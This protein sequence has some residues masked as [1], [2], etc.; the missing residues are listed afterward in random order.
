MKTIPHRPR[1]NVLA[2]AIALCIGLAGGMPAVHADAPRARDITGTAGAAKQSDA[3]PARYT[4]L[5][6]EP[7]LA[8]YQGGIGH[9]AEPPRIAGGRHAGRL[10][11]HS[12]AATAW[13]AHL[14]GQQ[15]A[16][17][18]DA[19]QQVSRTLVPVFTFQHALNGV[20]VEL[21]PAEADAIARRA[22]VLL[23]ERER[24][25]ELQTDRGPAF[26]GADTIWDGSSTGGIATQGEGVVAGIIDT[27]INWESP[28]FAATGPIDAY[29]H[30]NPLGAGTYLGLCGPTPPNADLGRC[31]D[32]LIG[33][34]NF[35]STSP[36][37]S[38]VDTQGHGSHTASTVA[39][40]HRDAPFGGGTFRISGVA[41][42]ANVVAYLACPSSCPTSATAASV[43][44]AVADGV[45]DVLNFS[46]SGGTSP[47][48][49]STSLAF[50][51]AHNAGIFVAASAGNNGPGA[52]T[53]GHVEPWTT[54][55]AAST[56]D[57]V[58]GFTLNLT[59]PGPVPPAA[60]DIPMRPG[61]LPIQVADIVDAPI[62]RSP[63]FDDGSNDGCSAYP[64]GTFER[65]GNGALAVLHLDGNASNCASGV[66]RSAAIAAGAVGVI[67]VDV[68]YLNLG[69][70]D[71]S[72]S[73]LMSDWDAVYAQI[74]VDP[75][76]ATASALLPATSFPGVGDVIADFS[77]RGPNLG[78]GGQFLVK[79][80]ISAP[81]VDILAAYVGGPDS[82]ALENGT[83]MS[84]PHIAGSAVLLRGVHPG[85]TPMQVKSALML[86]AKSEGL[87]NVD[88]TP[89]DPWD[90]GAGRVDLAAAARTGL[91]MDETGAN[92]SAA[93][94]AAG[95]TLL[96]LNLPSAALGDCTT[97][98]C[99]FTR[100]VQSALAVPAEWTLDF[101]DL[102]GATASPATFMLAPGATQAIT[103]DLE[104]ATLAGDWSFGAL[105]AVSDADGVS[106]S[107]LPIAVR[108][109]A[110]GP[111]V[112]VSTVAFEAS[113]AAGDMDS[114]TLTIGNAGSG[115]LEWSL[116]V[117]SP[118]CALPAWLDATPA[119]GSLA[120][121]A[122]EEVDLAL[123]TGTL[124][125]G[126]YSTSLCIAS[127]DAGVPLVEI[128]VNLEVEPN[129][130]IFGNGFD[131]P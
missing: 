53:L 107:H 62:I 130:R 22:D 76:T 83:S 111:L 58:L 116:D 14:V 73:I 44:Q 81:G 99:S 75:A 7:A 17:L 13:I 82:V 18:A 29:E 119:S 33:M 43:N 113:I 4:I 94:P 110:A 3:A 71:T 40:N 1:A 101:S 56:H 106:V 20:V 129:D 57:R 32:K 128:G 65:N 104:P 80:E 41:P 24:E 86:N 92:F 90:R 35:A 109:V 47:W 91:V 126:A 54:T 74:Q 63:D 6:R 117:A 48:A 37:R 42:H 23:V 123:D 78:L 97:G 125:E 131:G 26:I 60:Q 61:A 108:R 39:G 85:W 27:G 30:E 67:F 121:G 118:G 114:E 93:N 84:S 77:S 98:A 100:T 89:G 70:A 127:N 9:F 36:T 25:Y 38:A 68:V 11:V 102:P 105:H 5:L 122:S 120:A 124:P 2:S 31:N 49:D 46:I 64:A 28:S 45:I 69:A 59:A 96:L 95:G 55:V 8:S 52:S 19:S 72:W 34:Y 87:V 103:I 66:R 10:D 15:A 79:P 88:G 115:T 16:F 50:L 21:A 12:A 51:G 112:R